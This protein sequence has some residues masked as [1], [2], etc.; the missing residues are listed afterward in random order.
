MKI[1]NGF[2][3]NSSSSSFVIL[4]LK[5]TPE[6]YHALE[7]E[8]L[9]TNPNLGNLY[10]FCDELDFDFTNTEDVDEFIGEYLAYSDELF[11]DLR[12][13][14]FDYRS[15]KIDRLLAITGKTRSDL[16]IAIGTSLN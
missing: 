12:V 14:D 2:V 15:E 9:K 11:E 5:L 4:A 7:K 6:I 3:S 13:I 1:R 10:D 16:K 8:A